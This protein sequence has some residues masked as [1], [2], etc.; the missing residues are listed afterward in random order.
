[1]HEDAE[2]AKLDCVMGRRVSGRGACAGWN[3][4]EGGEGGQRPAGARWTPA[5]KSAFSAA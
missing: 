2:L 3:E 5:L 4:G 1:M